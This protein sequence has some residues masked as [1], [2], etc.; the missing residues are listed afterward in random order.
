MGFIG[1]EL[2]D[3]L[4]KNLN[5]F[6]E[7][8][9]RG[10]FLTFEGGDGSGKSTQSELFVKFFNDIENISH[11]PVFKTFEPG[12]TEMGKTLRH[13]I[14]Y[15]SIELNNKTEALLFAADRS[16]HVENIIKPKLKDNFLVVSDRYIDSS[17]A[18]Q[19]AAR[20]MGVEEIEKLSLWAT[21]NLTPDVTFLFDINRK[22]RLERLNEK[23]Q[24]KLEK[25][26][27]IFHNEVRMEYLKLVG[28]YRRIILLDGSL[29][30]DIVFKNVLVSLND[31]VKS[32]NI[33]SLKRQKFFKNY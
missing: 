15:S 4:V 28:K 5:K 16:F 26:G 8:N 24:D 11:L 25:A 18:Y 30:K 9:D 2:C 33:K 22:T 20:G 19:G 7:L 13:L 17:V 3:D 12:S 21:D 32:L 29:E 23:E 27:D 1:E 31:R 14:Q 6:I 10:L